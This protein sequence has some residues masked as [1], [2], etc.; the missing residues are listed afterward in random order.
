MME[1][2]K[3]RKP[4]SIIIVT[5][6]SS[7]SIRDCLTP[8]AGMSDFEVVVVDNNSQDNC[9]AL[10]EREFPFA[11]VISLETNVGFGRACN[12][13]VAASSGKYIVLMNPDSVASPKVIRDQVKFLSDHHKTGIVGGRLIDSLGRPLQSMGDRPSLIGLVL[14]KPL[15]WLAKRAK[16]QGFLRQLLGRVSSKFRLSEEPEPAVWVSGA[17]LCCRR[18]AWDQIAGF[19]ENFFLYYEDVDLCLRADRAGWEVYHNPHAV[20]Q[21]RSGASFGGDLNKQKKF[22]YASQDYFFRKYHHPI[23]A[24][25]FSWTQGIYCRLGLFHQFAQDRIGRHLV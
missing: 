15:A 20:I 17:F 19:D 16:C 24:F 11:R 8:F 23:V 7:F 14:D 3:T 1:S 22:Y 9:A 4:C 5:Y 10:V 25:L 18:M 21:H 13:G 12:I 2:N 6:N